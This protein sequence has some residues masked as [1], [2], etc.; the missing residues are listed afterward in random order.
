MTLYDPT[1]SDEAAI[2][3]SKAA[4]RRIKTNMTRPTTRD[5]PD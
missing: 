3:H 2:F 5:Q 1:S 4:T